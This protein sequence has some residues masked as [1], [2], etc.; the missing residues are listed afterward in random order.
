MPACKQ[1][2]GYG[3]AGQRSASA[4]VE[5]SED[6]VHRRVVAWLNLIYRLNQQTHNDQVFEPRPRNPAGKKQMN[7]ADVWSSM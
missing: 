6:C 1:N 5:R 2:K 7:C 4:S 3:L